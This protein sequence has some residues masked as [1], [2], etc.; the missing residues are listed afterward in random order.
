MSRVTRTAQADA[1][2]AE[3]W[4]YLSRYSTAAADRVT[5]GIDRTCQRLGRHPG[6]GRLREELAPGLRSYPTPDGYIVFYVAAAGGVE[7]QRVMYG[8]RHVDPSMF[9]V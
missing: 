2:I 4:L 8:S 3:I 5:D 1:D 7:V 6:L 9:D